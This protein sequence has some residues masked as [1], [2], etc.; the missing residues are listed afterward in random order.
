MQSRVEQLESCQKGAFHIKKCGDWI[1][2]ADI[3]LKSNQG[4]CN[5]VLS[6]YHKFMERTLGSDH[7]GNK[8]CMGKHIV[9]VK[10]CNGSKTHQSINI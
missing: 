8:C 10:I 4:G 7:H 2:Q 6:V 9:Q 3:Q 1:P 5:A